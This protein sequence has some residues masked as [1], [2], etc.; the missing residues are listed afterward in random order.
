MI[1][2]LDQAGKNSA[3]GKK[4]REILE[5]HGK[6]DSIST[7]LYMHSFRELGDV[8]RPIRVEG[9]QMISVLKKHLKNEVLRMDSTPLY[10]DDNKASNL[11]ELLQLLKQANHRHRRASIQIINEDH[12]QIG[13]L[14]RRA[15]LNNHFFYGLVEF[16][17]VCNQILLQ[18][19]HSV[20]TQVAHRALRS[21]GRRDIESSSQP[22]LA[23]FLKITSIREAVTWT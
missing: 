8:L 1:E 18:A 2:I 9:D 21:Y 23:Q 13:M 14:F 17:P 3:Q 20:E 5:E 16:L 19:K 10:V 7:W 22:S 12:E 4:L 15:L 11:I 6:K